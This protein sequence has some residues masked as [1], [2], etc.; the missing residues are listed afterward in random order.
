MNGKEVFRHAVTRMSEAVD[1]AMKKNDVTAEEI[2]FL[3][4]HQA[5]R[6][7]IEAVAD[8]LHLSLDKIVLTLE[9]QANTSAASIPLALATAVEDGRITHGDLILMEALGAG[10]T[11]ASALVRM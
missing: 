10:L 1:A 2:S 11:W 6:R 3:V 7:I 8:K 4:P 9:T 5:N